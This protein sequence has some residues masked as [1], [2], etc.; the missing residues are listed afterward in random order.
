MRDDMNAYP[1]KTPIA[2]VAGVVALVVAAMLALSACSSGAGDRLANN[3]G[4]ALAAS[5][6]S[7]VRNSVAQDVEPQFKLADVPAYS[8]KPSV[9]VN[10]GVPYFAESDLK[11]DPFESYSALDKLGRC[12]VAYALIGPETMPEGE[13]GSIGMVEPSGWRISKYDWID[14]KYLFNRCHLIA[15]AL[16]GENDNPRNLITGT[17]SMNAQG[18]LPYEER[19]AHYVD[20]TGNHVLYRVTPVYEG[21]NPIASGVLMEAK[22]VEDAGKRISFCVWCYNV[23]PGVVIDYE[24]GE[25]REGDPV[26]GVVVPLAKTMGVE[27]SAQSASAEPEAA[28]EEE[29][30]EV[31]EAADE[32]PEQAE[33]PEAADEHVVTYILNTRS[34]KFHYPDCPSVYA[35]KDKNKAEFEGSRDEAIALGYKPCGNCNP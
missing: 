27:S 3:V 35:M 6:S 29:A 16:A 30:A 26:T 5:K 23:E 24:T 33:E 11:L 2:L 9:V 19:V 18:M 25:N 17:R 34:H 7:A 13:R 21:D 31:P 1:G 8:G 10:G 12:G 4:S 32:P 20:S 28:E 22:S 15:H 14:G